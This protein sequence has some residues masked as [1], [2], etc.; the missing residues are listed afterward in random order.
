MGLCYSGGLPALAGPMVARSTCNDR[1]PV[2]TRGVDADSKLADNPPPA[3]AAIVTPIVSCRVCL[4]IQRVQQ[5]EF[6]AISSM[7]R[8]LLV[9]EPMHPAMETRQRSTAWHKAPN[10][11][12]CR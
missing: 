12:V 3:D 8:G 2:A 9:D 11:S 4:G 5:L 1:R 6:L 10:L 7:A